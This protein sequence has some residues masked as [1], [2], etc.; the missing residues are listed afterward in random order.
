MWSAN[1]ER[2]HALVTPSGFSRKASASAG[3]GLSRGH[4]YNFLAV[5]ERPQGADFFY[6]AF[7][8]M[9]IYFLWGLCVSGGGGDG[10]NT[11]DL[12]AC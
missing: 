5:G 3:Q 8:V 4:K 12:G 7:D 11:W 1:P 10:G 6:E 2:A 9:E